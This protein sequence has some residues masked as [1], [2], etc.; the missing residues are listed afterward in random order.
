MRLINKL[1]LETNSVIL[2]MDIVKYPL[3]D[4]EKVWNME[5]HGKRI[6]IVP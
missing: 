3:R 6:V 2:N 4:I 1:T 5:A